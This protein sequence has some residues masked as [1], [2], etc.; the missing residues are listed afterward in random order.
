MHL[1][2]HTTLRRTWAALNTHSTTS[3]LTSIMACAHNAAID[4]ML[5]RFETMILELEAMKIGPHHAAPTTKK[6][7][8]PEPSSS[9]GCYAASRQ[10]HIDIIKAVL[11]V[12]F[13][14]AATESRDSFSTYLLKRT[15]AELKAVQAK[16]GRTP[17]DKKADAVASILAFLD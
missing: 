5:A 4:K 12:N 14:P 15:V 6:A 7:P 13:K 11:G 3:R 2:T 1:I 17:L 8:T 16:F 9:G 10:A